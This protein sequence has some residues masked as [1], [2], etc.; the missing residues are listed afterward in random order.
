MPSVFSTLF[1]WNLFGFSIN[2][3]GR[4]EYETFPT[5]YS[6]AKFIKLIV[7][8]LLLSIIFERL[9]YTFRDYY[10]RRK[11]DNCIKIS[12]LENFSNS[13]KVTQINLINETLSFISWKS[14]FNFLIS[15]FLFLGWKGFIHTLVIQ[16]E[17]AI[18]LKSPFY[19][20]LDLTL[21]YSQGNQ[22]WLL[23]FGINS[24]PN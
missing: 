11:M 21:L 19:L 7:F 13:W 3:S 17:L 14:L 23:K 5:P 8:T 20:P 18:F 15:I 12:T 9:F 6:F 4:R 1:Y 10:T 16:Q 22:A 24:I 2:C